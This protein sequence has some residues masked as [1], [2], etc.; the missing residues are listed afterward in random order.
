MRAAAIAALVAALAGCAA[1]ADH[2]D[3]VAGL[4]ESGDARIDLADDQDLEM[5]RDDF[6]ALAEDA[7]GRTA[8]RRRLVAELARRLSAALDHG[9]R[10]GGHAALR[11]ILSLWSAAEL[12]APGRIAPELAAHRAVLAGARA[13]YARAGLDREAVAALAALALAEPARADTW[14]AEIDEIFAYA[15]ELASADDGP[16]KEAPRPLELLD[17]LSRVHPA[18]WVID[19]LV[20][21]Q[22]AHRARAA[23]R[24]RRGR[25]DAGLL[26][27]DP[28]WRAAWNI[29]AALARG[30]RLGEA[31]RA[32]AAIEGI[33]DDRELRERLRRIAARGA[34]A[35]DW[36]L[37]ADRFRSPDPR[38]GDAGAALAVALEGLARFPGDPAL[39]LAAADAAGR[40]GRS[41]L[42][43][44]HYERGLAADPRDAEAVAALGRLH[45]ERLS[46]LVLSDRPAAAGRALRAFRALHARLTAALGHAIEP[47]LADAE[48]A[49]GRGLA[50]TGEIDRARRLLQV[51]IDRRPTLDALESLGTL[52]LKQDRFAEA[53]D[54]FDRAVARPAAEPLARAQQCRILRLAAEAHHGAGRPDEARARARAAMM[55]WRQLMEGAGIA[56][57]L[58]GDALVEQGRLLWL[59]GERDAARAA[60]DAAV[61]VSP[62][63]ASVHADVVSF[64]IVRG[65]Y[66]RAVDAYHGA[67]G[68]DQIGDYFKVYMSL[69]V[70]AEARRQ[71]R[72]ADPLARDFLRGR[73]GPLWYDDL[74]RFADGRMRLAALERRATTPSRRAELLYY[75]A[76]LDPSLGRDPARA[77]RMLERVVATDMVMFFEYDM[78]RHWLRHG[79]TPP[80]QR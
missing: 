32:T 21:R 11:S 60:F 19:R 13:W 3:P 36:V 33:G 31:A 41:A 20:A 56:R 48:A 51:S 46:A 24:A 5:A 14:R 45:I 47:D 27:A 58:A 10:A 43:I 75:R 77:R 29:T 18:P 1:P 69:W 66:D 26:R 53:I 63:D 80:R 54:A 79:F 40:L 50:S 44:R 57:V 71:G 16:M 73:E 74:A 15:D 65:E 6:A 67:L 72:P 34:R 35:A 55:G 70:T 59:L 78:A 42:A 2:G 12:R 62:D 39:H 49:F 61:D 4:R 64:L 7:A 25:R 76:V 22:L 68:S 17:A 8:L 23:S 38:R 30:G 28:A 52:A 37:L 9:D